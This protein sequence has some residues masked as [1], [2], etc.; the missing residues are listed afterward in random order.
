MDGPKNNKMH[1]YLN[2]L[3]QITL[4][5]HIYRRHTSI[6]KHREVCQFKNNICIVPELSTLSIINKIW[7]DNWQD[8]EEISLLMIDKKVSLFDI[9]MF[10]NNG[11]ESNKKITILD[12]LNLDS[13]LLF[14]KTIYKNEFGLGK[15]NGNKFLVLPHHPDALIPKLITRDNKILLYAVKM[16]GIFKKCKSN[17]YVNYKICMDANEINKFYQVSHEMIFKRFVTHTYDLKKGTNTFPF[18]YID[19]P[20]LYMSVISKPDDLEEITM[21]STMDFYDYNK[22][23]HINAPHHMKIYRTH[24][25]PEHCEF[26]MEDRDVYI[27]NCSQ[28]ILD[29]N[30]SVQPSGNFFMRK[31]SQITI[32]ANKNTKITILYSMYNVFRYLLFGKY[33][34][35][36]KESHIGFA[37][38]INT[39]KNALPKNKKLH[40]TYNPQFIKANLPNIEGTNDKQLVLDGK[41]EL[42]N[43]NDYNDETKQ[44]FEFLPRNTSKFYN[45]FHHENDYHPYIL[46]PC[47]KKQKNKFLNMNSD[48]MCDL[49]QNYN[50]FNAQKQKIESSVCA[51]TKQDIEI[52]DGYHKCQ[53]CNT[54]FSLEGIQAYI[55]N[56]DS[57]LECPLCRKEINVYP[58]YYVNE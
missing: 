38:N 11:S 41:S 43:Y 31:D 13:L 40:D 47:N 58:K 6:L 33:D 32:V 45:S 30:L 34:E 19:T 50:I 52:G 3:P 21:M 46:R 37:Y 56:N 36:K 1:L 4:N 48:T 39:D 16:N 14:N 53:Q 22:R 20:I 27:L 44:Q 12:K 57:S 8:I 26:M 10:I 54:I 42:S 29:Q 15:K 51:I 2:N 18:P 17:I 23:K 35:D 7:I 55:L 9:K 25:D 5:K 49:I 24:D 28:S